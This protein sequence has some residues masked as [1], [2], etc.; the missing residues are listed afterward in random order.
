MMTTPVI[1]SWF[2]DNQAWLKYLWLGLVALGVVIFIIIALRYDKKTTSQ[3]QNVR[4]RNLIFT[5]I[6]AGISFVLYMLRFPLPFAFPSFLD[7]QV[8]NV[9][10]FIAGFSLGPIYGAFVVLIRMLLKLPFTSTVGVGELADFIIGL[11]A[12]L[13]SS[14]IYERHK[15][16]KGAIVSLAFASLAWVCAAVV[17]NWLVLVPFYIKLFFNGELAPFLNML[18]VIPGVTEKNYMALYLFVSVVP[19]NILLSALVSAITFLI[20]KNISNYFHRREEVPVEK[21][22]DKVLDKEAEI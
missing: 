2:K 22:A 3:A 12:V 14:F 4:I 10:A 7:I 1:L 19:F 20:Y 17:M 9:P 5:A 21:E 18:A 16:K 6:L 8:S 11:I 15:T 13:V